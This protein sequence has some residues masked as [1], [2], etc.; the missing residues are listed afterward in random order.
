MTTRKLIVLVA[1][2]PVPIACLSM[3]AGC[4]STG[5][6]GWIGTPA[7]FLWPAAFVPPLLVVLVS[8]LAWTVR[9]GFTAARTSRALTK[10]PRG[11]VPPAV[12]SAARSARIE[13][14]AY[15]QG[16]PTVAFCA[17]LLRPTV[18]I[19]EEATARLSDSELMAVLHHEAD[20]ARRREPVRRAARTA[21]AEALMFF[22]LVAWWTERQAVRSE[23]RADTAAVLLVGRPA[24]AGALLVMTD[25]AV[26]MAAFAGHT[27]LRARRLLGMEVEEGKPP[28]ALWATTVA[29]SWLTLSLAGCL[30]E[31][32]VGLTSRGL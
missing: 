4:S 16:G 20:H 30:S 19:T 17:G 12:A 29:Y 32:L 28:P 24:L 1:L 14:I 7:D 8:A 31:V 13:R 9:F 26:A 23:L 3:V 10:L 2:A 25:P 18:F 6:C 5:P 27:E 22:P 21:A 15:I 11:Q